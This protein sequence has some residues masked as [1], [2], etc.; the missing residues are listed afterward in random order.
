M[1]GRDVKVHLNQ[2]LG[3]QHSKDKQSVL[4]GAATAAPPENFILVIMP[5]LSRR[6]CT[7]LDKPPR[8]EPY[9]RRAVAPRCLASR[10]A[11]R[12]SRL[13][14]LEWEVHNLESP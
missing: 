2:L 3:D 5:R 4:A 11:F 10:V 8:I 9:G 14:L 6:C 1:D 7:G 13:V 12:L